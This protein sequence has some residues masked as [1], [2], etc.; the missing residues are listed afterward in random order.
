[1]DEAQDRGLL[2]EPDHFEEVDVSDNSQLM[3][4]SRE[5]SSS[6]LD[7]VDKFRFTYFAMGFLGA[8]FLFP[9]SSTLSALDY[10]IIRCKILSSASRN[11]ELNP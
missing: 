6:T 4:D 11:L 3:T 10:Y 7:P 2:T 8:G 9:W 5:P 1:M